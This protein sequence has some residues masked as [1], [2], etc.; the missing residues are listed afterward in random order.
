MKL[1][2]VAVVFISTLVVAGLSGCGDKADKAQAIGTEQQAKDM[3]AAR[4]IFDA[5]HGDW[6]KTS[7]EDQQK[8]ENYVGGKERAQ[9]VWAKMVNPY[10][11]GPGAVKPQGDNGA[12]NPYG[13]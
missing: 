8:F 12:K 2:L 7:P 4:K 1:K 3:L 5:N 9:A 13:G 10:A 11:P 6:S